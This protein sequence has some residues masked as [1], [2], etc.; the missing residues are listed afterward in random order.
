MIGQ[1]VL[2]MNKAHIHT[3]NI[4]AVRILYRRRRSKQS[5]E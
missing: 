5:V 2:S 4:H 3:P 1:M